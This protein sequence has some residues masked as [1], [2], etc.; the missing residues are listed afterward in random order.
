MMVQH[1][2]IAAVI[3]CKIRKANFRTK[4]GHFISVDAWLQFF[5][6][7]DGPVEIQ[8]MKSFVFRCANKNSFL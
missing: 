7:K 1:P 4:D 2:T 6:S 3:N 5:S 8:N